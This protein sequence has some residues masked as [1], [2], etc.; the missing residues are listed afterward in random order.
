MST[1]SGF[2]IAARALQGAGA[3]ALMP[4]SL[5]LVAASVP[6]RLRSLAIGIWG[7]VAGLG[8]ALGPLIGGAVVQGWNW[9]AIFWINVPVGIVAIALVIY[10]LPNSFGARV[11]A[12]LIGVALAGLGVLGV[13]F[14]VVRGNQAG[15]TSAQV[16]LGLIGGTLLLGLFIRRESMIPAPLLPLR[17]FR[18]RSF[19][20]INL[21][22]LTF[23]FGAFG[24]VF[25][26][27]QFL[28]V[29][30][31]KTPLQA[32]LMTMPWTLAPMFV[33]PLAGFVAPRVGTRPLVLTGASLL[34]AGIFWTALQMS[35]DE[36]YSLMVPG[37]L[38]AG[39]G[40]GL[41]FAP[42]S[43]AVL[44]NM[45]PED[46]AKASGTNS[47]LREIGVALG[48]AVL[49]AIFTGAGGTLT[50]TGYVDAARPA[51]FAGG[52]RRR[53]C[54]GLRRFPACGA[55]GRRIRRCGRAGRV[56]RRHGLIRTP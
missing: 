16:L 45:A 1:D 33:A 28:Q 14:G 9:Q 7:G 5:T 46:H 49:T 2:L 50:P 6:V 18:D 17:L 54:R 31:G 42:S 19:S 53:T 51:V 10:A 30:Q 38:L 26:L 12:D 21:V 29:V 37:F 22:G 48:I 52:G 44:V 36:A 39:I 25:I 13:V 27:I 23:S 35:I 56:G 24:A 43:T 8:V 4:L 47:T 55:A 40:M 34:S 15:W 3:A 41:I 32:G 11:P 20:V